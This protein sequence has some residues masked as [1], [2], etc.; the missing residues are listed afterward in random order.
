MDLA[1][2]KLIAVTKENKKIAVEE[3]SFAGTSEL[4]EFEK[5]LGQFSIYKLAIEEKE[6]DRVLYLAMPDDF[7]RDFMEDPFFQKITQIYSVKIITF[8]TEK[9]EIVAWKN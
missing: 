1:A 4:T 9:E 8:D 2:D 6:A 7:Y 5:A 3:K